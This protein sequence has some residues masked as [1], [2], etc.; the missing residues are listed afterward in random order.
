MEKSDDFRELLYKVL[1]EQAEML[2]SYL[3]GIKSI[4]DI[5]T[6]SSISI[7]FFAR[8]YPEI[9]FVTADIADMR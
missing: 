6:G 2:A 7:H 4:L 3:T 8:K 5:G 9:E 1:P